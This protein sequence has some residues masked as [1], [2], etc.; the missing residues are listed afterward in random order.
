VHTAIVLS[1]TSKEAD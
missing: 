1:R